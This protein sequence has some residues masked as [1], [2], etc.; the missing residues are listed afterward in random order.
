MYYTSEYRTILFHGPTQ[1]S[2]GLS[3][4]MPQT[5]Q[6]NPLYPRVMRSLFLLVFGTQSKGEEMGCFALHF[7]IQR[8]R[9]TLAENR[10]QS[11]ELGLYRTTYSDAFLLCVI[12]IYI[13]I[14]IYTCNPFMFGESDLN[15][16]FVQGTGTLHPKQVA[17]PVNARVIIRGSSRRRYEYMCVHTQYRHCRWLVALSTRPK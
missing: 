10:N 11:A 9:R 2:A 5:T 1:K 14:Y 15:L 4:T 6:R 8:S 17:A 3:K 12:Y 16:V 7:S 13:Y